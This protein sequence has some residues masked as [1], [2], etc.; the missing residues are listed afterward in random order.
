MEAWRRRLASQRQDLLDDDE[1]E[2]MALRLLV[3][4]MGMENEI[5]GRPSPGGS[6]PGKRENIDREREVGYKRIMKDYFGEDP[7]Y[8]PHLFRRRF[9]MQWCLFL[10]IMHEVCA[11]D[12]YFVQKRNA[13]GVLGLSSVQKCTAALRMLAYGTSGDAMD[14]YCR[15]SESTAMEAM[16]RFVVA[17]RA[18]FEG[19]YLRQPTHEDILRQMGI[20]EA[21][22]F[23][24]MF[25]S[26]DC[27]YW[28]WKNCPMAWAGQFQNKD[29]KRSIVL[30]AVA[31][32]SLWIWHAYFGMP[33]SNND[34]NVLDRS[35]LVTNMLRGPSD[36]LT[37]TVNG[38]QYS[39]YYL[40]TDG[41]YP[42]WSCFV[43]TI[44]SPQDEKRAHYSKMQE[45]TRKDVERCFGVLQGRFAI[46]ANPSKL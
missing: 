10:R 11:Y 17:I 19:R 14:E 33:G 44:H 1:E 12:S 28:A 35:P 39:R 4:N 18:C 27:M 13:A 32:Q 37:F 20:N 29:K 7:V 8:P 40:L 6:R 25:A 5:Q 22:G 3:E 2:E 24:G 16:T 43:Q 30:E 9:R 31:D 23:P 41:I 15:L 45:S 34:V 26:I 42:P 21:R 46:L 36:D 38:K